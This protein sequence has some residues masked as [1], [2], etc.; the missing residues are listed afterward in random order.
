[1]E[2]ILT[3]D[4]LVKD[5]VFNAGRLFPVRGEGG[6]C[7]QSLKCGLTEKRLV[8]PAKGL[9]CLHQ[10]CM[11]LSSLFAHIERIR[12]WECPLCLAPL[13]YYQIFIDLRVKQILSK[14]AKKGEMLTTRVE[15][16]SDGSWKP[17]KTVDPSLAPN[18]ISSID[19]P[20]SVISLYP[21]DSNSLTAKP[22][23]SFVDKHK[24]PAYLLQFPWNSNEVLAFDFSNHH[25]VPV[26]NMTNTLRKYSYFTAIYTTAVD[27]YLCGGVDYEYYQTGLMHHFNP[28]TGL[29][30]KKAMNLPRSHFP[31][32]HLSESIFVFGGLCNGE[33]LASSEK[34]SIAQDQWQDVAP[35]PA[36]R[37]CH[38]AAARV[39]QTIMVIAGSEFSGQTST[40]LIYDVPHDYW[41]ALT[42]SLPHLV[43]SPHTIA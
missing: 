31:G 11:E 40:I 39:D 2:G 25:W 8:N 23:A 27:L 7:L 33:T 35:M 19:S 29:T 36:G 15:I 28:G 1:M 18:P 16:Y 37:S 17:E 4:D 13:P 5:K 42:L 41:T 38:I 10:A 34:Y 9:N 32:V 21:V 6:T 14:L 20:N 43:E 12:K 26:V 24:S 3:W 30:R 22:L